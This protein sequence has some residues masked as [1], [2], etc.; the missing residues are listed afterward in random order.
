MSDRQD[1]GVVEVG[2][3]GVLDVGVS[4]CVDG[5]GRLYIAS[6]CYP[7][8][9]RGADRL[10]LEYVVDGEAP[11]LEQGADVDLLKR[12]RHLLP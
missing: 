3:D 12:L 10:V 2:P 1:R 6:A 8:R 9:K 5:R 7:R 11:L 4:F